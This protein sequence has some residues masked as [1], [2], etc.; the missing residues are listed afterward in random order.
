MV[1]HFIFLQ[2]FAVLMKSI[3]PTFI[4]AVTPEISNKKAVYPALMQ[5]LNAPLCKGSIKSRSV[6]LSLSVAVC[7]C[8][9]LSVSLSLSDEA[10]Y[11]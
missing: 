1:K 4:D 10:S 9:S 3:Q 7:L 6:C 2:K 8:L 11:E 5:S